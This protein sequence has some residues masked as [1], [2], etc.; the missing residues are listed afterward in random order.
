MIFEGNLHFS[1][2]IEFFCRPAKNTALLK[3]KHSAPKPFYRKTATVWALSFCLRFVLIILAHRVM[4]CL[5]HH[6]WQARNW[7]K[8]VHPL[9][10]ILTP[11]IWKTWS[12]LWLKFLDLSLISHLKLDGWLLLILSPRGKKATFFKHSIEVKFIWNVDI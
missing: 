7:W 10:S 12:E 9:A 4:K 5:K 2:I 3:W 6:G 1:S 11:I 8:W